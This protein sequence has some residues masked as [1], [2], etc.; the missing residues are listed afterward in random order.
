MEEGLWCAILFWNLYH[1]VVIGLNNLDASRQE[2][3]EAD[4]SEIL[5]LCPAHAGF[6]SYVETI[7]SIIEVTFWLVFILERHARSESVVHDLMSDYQSTQ[8]TEM[9]ILTSYQPPPL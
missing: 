4:M 8:R 1:S 2:L 3:E 6:R 9:L 5:F 7:Y